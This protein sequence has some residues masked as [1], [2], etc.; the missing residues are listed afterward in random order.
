[1]TRVCD[2]VTVVV[3]EQASGGERVGTYTYI[4][5]P[6]SLSSSTPQHSLTTPS[7]QRH[8]FLPA[9]THK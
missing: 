2:S 7:T 9:R 1:M 4:T 3:E 8:G 6:P 5:S